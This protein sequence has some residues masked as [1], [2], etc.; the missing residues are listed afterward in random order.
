MSIPVYIM[1]E[2]KEAFFCWHYMIH[3]GEIGA[4]GNILVHVDD[5]TD[6]TP[7]DYCFNVADFPITLERAK[8]IAYEQVGIGDFIAPALF[9]N[10]F[11]T[12]VN[13]DADNSAVNG[14]KTIFLRAVNRN[15]LMIID[16]NNP[17]DIQ[18]HIN[19]IV[20]GERKD[21]CYFRYISGGLCNYPVLN[22]QDVILDVD[23]DYFASDDSL[24]TSDPQYVEI[25]KEYYDAVKAN[26]Y[27]PVR[28]FAKFSFYFIEAS[29]HYYMVRPH[30]HIFKRPILLN[31]Y[32][33]LDLFFNWLKNREFGIL[34]ID[35]CR[36]RLSGYL[37]RYLFPWLEEEFLRR[38]SEV[39]DI[40][41]KVKP[42]YNYP[43]ILDKNTNKDILNIRN[44]YKKNYIHGLETWTKKLQAD[45]PLL[46]KGINWGTVMA[47]ARDMTVGGSTLSYFL[48]VPLAGESGLDIS[49]A[50]SQEDFLGENLFIGTANED[51]GRSI[52]DYAM[53]FFRY[54]CLN[55]KDSI[56]A[57]RD[58]F[59]GKSEKKAVFFPIYDGNTFDAVK[60]HIEHQYSMQPLIDLLNKEGVLS[61]VMQIG[62]MSS[63]DE[64]PIRLVSLCPKNNI[65]YLL[66]YIERSQN[67]ELPE[68]F[69]QA[70]AE[71]GS[72]KELDFTVDIDIY[73]N[74]SVGDVVGLELTFD[75]INLPEEYLAILGSPVVH[76]FMNIIYRMGMI[77]DRAREITSVLWR[78]KYEDK[79]KGPSVMLSLLSHL[80]FRWK[81][82]KALPAKIYLTMQV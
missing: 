35:I 78:T 57:E 33:R 19:E 28:N 26:T 71:L 4:T 29:G 46:F 17:N 68:D 23:L 65:K 56:F 74:G 25:T 41:I 55:V 80:K 52:S 11:S 72:I 12:V 22:G 77:D 53:T 27:H 3:S 30:R 45:A 15:N 36:S 73:Q 2:H 70:C 58:I 16:E 9:Q 1:E 60:E 40:D 44:A 67:M 34:A 51:L 6:M 8:E 79:I 82:G 47:A 18:R 21:C 54:G 10:L 13:I 5:H 48:E 76:N 64:C 31:I 69:K 14:D 7:D 32:R 49:F 37:P 38:L 61:E 62:I 24:G 63:R 39:V 81:N 42:E 66:S 43:D 50:Y 59:S 20:S 75:K